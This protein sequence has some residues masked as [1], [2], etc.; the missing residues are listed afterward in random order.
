RQ[1][2]FYSNADIDK[3]VEERIASREKQS[4]ASEKHIFEAKPK[5]VSQVDSNTEVIRQFIEIMKQAKKTLA[6][7]PGPGKEKADKIHI[8]RFLD[9]LAKVNPD[10][11]SS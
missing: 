4:P 5:Q 2:Q 11:D 9:D 6:K 3:L 8:D 1:Q 10:H 7:K